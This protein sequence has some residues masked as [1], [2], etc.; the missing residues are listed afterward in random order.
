MAGVPARPSMTIRPEA[1]GDRTAVHA[2]TTAAFGQ[3][4]EADLVDR[5]RERAEPYLALV[6]ED[7]GE[8]VGH[9]A[10][11]PVTAPGASGVMGLAPMAVQPEH[12]R[13]GIGSA[14]VRA[15]L[16]ACRTAGATAVV[17]LGHPAYYPRFGFAPAHRY[18]LRDAYGAPPEAFMALELAPDALANASGVVHYHDAFAG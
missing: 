7:N 5:L 4:N 17:V 18:G 12:Q 2:L 10:F 13:R 8:T 16:E 6:A 15:G 14:L 9:I 1:S 11:T 3:P